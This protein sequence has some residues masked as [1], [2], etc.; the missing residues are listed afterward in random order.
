MW[1]MRSNQHSQPVTTPA[2]TLVYSDE[3]RSCLRGEDHPSGRHD[4]LGVY[5]R[6]ARHVAKL[7]AEAVAIVAVDAGMTEADVE[8]KLLEGC[9]S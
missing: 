8:Q 7:D 4:T 1:G 3:C 5:E 6:I 9:L 2:L